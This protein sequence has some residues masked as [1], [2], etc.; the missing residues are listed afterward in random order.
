MMTPIPDTWASPATYDGPG[1]WHPMHG[2]A[3]QDCQRRARDKP[4]DCVC[5]GC[6]TDEVHESIGDFHLTDMIDAAQCPA[7]RRA[8][9]R[10][11]ASRL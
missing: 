9:E 4:R 8:L 1:R 7:E 5:C 10:I 11:L 2:E 3:W 6:H